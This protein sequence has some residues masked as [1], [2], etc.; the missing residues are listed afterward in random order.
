VILTILLLFFIT[1]CTKSN[2][3]LI[4]ILVDDEIT[5]ENLD[6][7]MFR[8]DVQYVDLRNYDASFRSGFIYSFELIPF[9]DYLDYRVFDRNDTYAFEPSQLL[10]EEELYRLFDQDKAIFLFADGCIRSDY[11]KEALNYLGYERVYVLGGFYE[12][13]G[14]YKVLGD[15][16]YSFGNTFYGMYV[17]DTSSMTYYVYGTYE[18]DRTITSIRFDIV[19]E[20]NVT[21]RSLNYDGSMDYNSQLTILENYIVSQVITMNDLYVA[22]TSLES[23]NFQNIEGFTLGFDDGIIGVIDSLTAK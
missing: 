1:G 18:L 5:M 14:E 6:D 4:P 22:I 10:N 21:L 11:L 7:Y 17:D 2:D 9:F 12:Y 15:G 19:D 3:D 13:F 20:N 16:S 8:D 23:N